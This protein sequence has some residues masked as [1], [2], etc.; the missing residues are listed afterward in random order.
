MDLFSRKILSFNIYNK[1]DSNPV[2][3][4][5]K[6]AFISRNF[7]K[8]LIFHSDR[9]AEY[10]SSSFRLFL[11]KH[12]VCQSFSKKTYPYDNACV[13][14]FFKQIKS[15]EI[16]NNHYTN[17]NDLFLACFEYIYRYN[18]KRPH[19]SLNYLTPNEFE[20]LFLI[21]KYILFLCLLY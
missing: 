21:N 16:Y 8:S 2:L 3:S 9:G 19:G 12:N 10:N 13:E 5:F 11:E 6:K 20:Q 18:N 1:H 7:P 4:T 17:F 14:S 15:E